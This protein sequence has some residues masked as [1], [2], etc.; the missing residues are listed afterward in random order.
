MKITSLNGVW[1][2]KCFPYKQE[3]PAYVI[4]GKVPGCVQLDLSENGYLPEDLF[5]GNN[6]L[7]TEELEGWDFEYEREFDFEGD[8]E[9][10]YLV[11]EGH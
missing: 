6:I 4:N 2:L 7:K 3:E 11:F 1:K 9:R 8:S 5:M 10:A